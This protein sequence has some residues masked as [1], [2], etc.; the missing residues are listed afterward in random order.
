MLK[1]LIYLLFLF[2]TFYPNS[3]KAKNINN[4]ECSTETSGL[5]LDI[6]FILDTSENAAIFDIQRQKGI[7]F[8][9]VV[10]SNLS[11]DNKKL[12]SSRIS[13]ITASGEANVI[14]DLN[15]F[16][17]DT[18]LMGALK[19]INSTR[20]DYKKLDIIKALDAADDVIKSSGRSLNYK[21]LVVLYSSHEDIHC[22]ENAR[23][24]NS[25]FDSDICR[26]AA[27][28]KNNGYDLMTIRLDYEGKDPLNK[29]GI[30]SPCYSL[31]FNDNIVENMLE[32]ALKSNCYCDKTYF[33]F[34]D[35]DICNKTAECIYLESTP[36][37]YSVAEMIAKDVK[38]ELVDIKSESKQNF[39]LSLA[40]N[41][42]PF[43][44]G[45]NQLEDNNTWKWDTG[46]SFNKNTDYNQFAL[47]EEEKKGMCASL[48]FDSKWYAVNCTSYAVNEP[49]IYQK[50]ACDTENFCSV[51]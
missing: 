20:T 24:K 38:A 36:A 2:N 23:I 9:F 28:F 46:Y 47:G 12:Q 39:L 33:Q 40:N 7:T 42:V 4:K 37:I 29:N 8:Q 25:L 34:Y 21:K 15:A 10:I 51:Y 14:G 27:E 45:L 11:M 44:I 17:T 16:T 26:R 13:L 19:S 18:E 50:S 35:N 41:S 30:A 43:F 6:V 1:V 32:L 3:V 22:E 49:Y 5:Y 31:D 48:N